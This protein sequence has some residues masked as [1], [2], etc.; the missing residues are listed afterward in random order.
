MS[1]SLTE[2]TRKSLFRR[3]IGFLGTFSNQHQAVDRGSVRSEIYIEGH[4][5]TVKLR[6]DFGWRSTFIQ[7]SVPRPTGR[8]RV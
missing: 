1:R 8:V 7:I 4:A 2:L 6:A 5:L 3:P